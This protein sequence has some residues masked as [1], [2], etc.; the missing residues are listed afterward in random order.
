MTKVKMAQH[1]EIYL[2]E[3]CAAVHIGFFRD[4]KLFAEAIPNYPELMLVELQ[5]AIAES[6]RRQGSNGVKH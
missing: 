5:Q 3:H 2:C 4:G 1:M 6:Q